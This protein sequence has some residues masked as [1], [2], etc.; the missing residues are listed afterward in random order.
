MQEDLDATALPAGQ[1][2]TEVEVI[3]LSGDTERVAAGL[4]ARDVTA[5]LAQERGIPALTK[6]QLLTGLRRVEDDEIIANAMG[7]LTATLISIPL[8][9]TGSSDF[10]L[11]LWNINTGECI[12]RLE[13][14][15]GAVVAVS[16][17]FEQLQAFSGSSDGTLR[18]WDLATLTCSKVM[19]PQCGPVK[20]AA[21]DFERNIA[22]SCYCSARVAHV[23]NLEVGTCLAALRGHLHD[24]RTVA[25]GGNGLV[26][27]GSVD[28]TLRV[29]SC[30]GKVT[31]PQC[32]KVLT[33]HESGVCSVC[34]DF[35]TE[36]ALSGADDGTVR[37]WD[38][39]IGQCLQRWVWHR[40]P[41]ISVMADF[42]EGS[43]ISTSGQGVVKLW[44]IWDEPPR[45][46]TLPGH[47]GLVVC[48]A[49]FS[50]GRA[51]SGGEEGT[52]CF[53][54]LHTFQCTRKLEAAHESPVN[55]IA[56]C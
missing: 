36:R 39:Q 50:A 55:A 40:W 41:V 13:G 34:A 42:S 6:V 24:V 33:G 22:I 21:A 45:E 12:G 18:I 14:H 43:A 38:L 51:V 56:C 31:G 49:D 53:W 52:L 16:A 7:P 44:R 29:W 35:R 20:D 17:N 30:L 54:D 10:T 46:E 32:L 19:T 3:W 2:Q 11:R 15:E 48:A 28:R 1:I 26:I 8:L 37:L 5:A 23:F 47:R 25:V 9:L 27:S 4:T